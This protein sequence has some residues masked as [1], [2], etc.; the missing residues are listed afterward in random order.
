MRA[1]TAPVVHL[2]GTS[3]EEL[4]DG[5]DAAQVALA[6]AVR[7]LEAASPNA[8]D[9]YVHADP[10]AFEAARREHEDRLQRLCSVRDELALLALAVHQQNDAR[11]SR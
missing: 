3:G 9:Y 2:N 11:R 4:A 8:R 5:Y 1:L 6:A 10:G 7:A